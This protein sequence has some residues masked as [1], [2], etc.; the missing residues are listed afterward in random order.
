M[1]A[2][3]R[4]ELHSNLCKGDW[5]FSTEH[6]GMEKGS[7]WGRVREVKNYRKQEVGVGPCDTHLCLLN[8]ANLIEVRPLPSHRDWET[9]P[10]LQVLSG[11]DR[12]FSWQ[13]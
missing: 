11:T 7:S 12:K 9:G 3:Q 8:G 4:D 1:T 2:G 5:T 13:P 10:S 6:E